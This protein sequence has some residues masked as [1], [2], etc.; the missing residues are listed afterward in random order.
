MDLVEGAGQ[1]SLGGAAERLRAMVR[2]AQFIVAAHREKP[3]ETTG[4]LVDI[5]HRAVPAAVRKAAAGHPAK[6]VFQAIRIAVND[7]LG[8]LAEAFRTAV[9][10][11]SQE[12]ALSSSPSIRW[13]IGLRRT[14][15]GTWLGGVFAPPI[16]PCV[17]AV[18]GQKFG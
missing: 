12:T 14:R 4:D 10:I 16:S 13:R 18:I 7:E 5:I 9:R 6:R 3:V 8:I 11:W 17:S 2:I 1:L 15:C